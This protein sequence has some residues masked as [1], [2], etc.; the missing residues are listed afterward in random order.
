MY[1][2]KMLSEIFL[3]RYFYL[4]EH[5]CCICLMLKQL[6]HDTRSIEHDYNE[7]RQYV[8]KHSGNKLIIDKLR[9]VLA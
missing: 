4:C 6:R 8:K 1:L 2:L 9:I 3:V 5:Y 7:K